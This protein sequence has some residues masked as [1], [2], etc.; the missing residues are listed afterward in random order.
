MSYSLT[1]IQLQRA[2]K[3]LAGTTNLFFTTFFDT[4]NLHAASDIE[5]TKSNFPY[6]ICK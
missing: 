6:E 5:L 4:A 2:S 3:T 1:T